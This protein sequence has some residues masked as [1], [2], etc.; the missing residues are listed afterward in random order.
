MPGC[1]ELRSICEELIINHFPEHMWTAVE[2]ELNRNGHIVIWGVTSRPQY[3]PIELMWAYSKRHVTHNKNS[4]NIIEV[5][6]RY[7]F[8]CTMGT[9]ELTKQIRMGWTGGSW[10]DEDLGMRTHKPVDAPLCKRFFDHA[11]S[12]LK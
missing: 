9:E 4:F 8:S 5:R 2:L 10:I 11:I 12:I 7:D 1:V 6:E 3:Q